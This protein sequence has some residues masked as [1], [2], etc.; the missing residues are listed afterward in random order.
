[1]LILN[2][3]LQG[4]FSNGNT[5]NKQEVLWFIRMYYSTIKNSQATFFGGLRKEDSYIHYY[6]TLFGSE[7]AA[8]DS[9]NEILNRDSNNAYNVNQAD[10][11]L[12]R[13]CS[14]R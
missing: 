6:A 4:G 9:K 7:V 1:M 2:S 11:R 3:I 14:A 12:V 13:K 8:V 5:S 10:S